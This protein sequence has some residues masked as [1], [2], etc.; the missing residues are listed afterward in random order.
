MPVDLGTLTRMVRF[1][2]DA[3]ETHYERLECFAPATNTATGDNKAYMHI[4]SNLN[5]RDLNSVHGEVATAGVTGTL[6]VMIR[7]GPSTDMLST[8][9]TIDT[10]E[11]G[12]DTAATPLVIKS[13]GSEAVATNDTVHV[14]VDG[15]HSGTAAIGLIITLGFKDPA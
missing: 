9:L 1:I 11:T 13:D 2:F 15:I 4:T 7:K 6:N 8:A 10:A 3:V 5:G 12:S 14:D